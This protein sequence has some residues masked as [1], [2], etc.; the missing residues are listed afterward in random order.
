MVASL[1]HFNMYILN[2]TNKESPHMCFCSIVLLG[3]SFIRCYVMQN[4]PIHPSLFVFCQHYCEYKHVMWR[5]FS[6]N[7]PPLVHSIKQLWKL[8]AIS[9]ARRFVALHAVHILYD[10]YHQHQTC[11]SIVSFSFHKTIDARPDAE[12]IAWSNW[13]AEPVQ[14]W[15][16]VILDATIH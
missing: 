10:C 5:W 7:E 11:L 9:T 6:S 1:H 13:N 3:L 15:I 16:S 2:P 14:L 12:W 4:L 8:I